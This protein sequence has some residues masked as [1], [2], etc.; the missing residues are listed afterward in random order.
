MF[1]TILYLRISP[2]LVRQQ[3]TDPGSSE[4]T[5]QDNHHRKNP[6]P[7]T[8]H[9]QSTKNQRYRKNPKRIH[10]KKTLSIEKQRITSDFFS[11]PMQ[12]RRE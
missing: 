5:K 3:T 11:E 8:Y 9:F 1:E 6:Y 4:N 12:A 10:R 7:Y 2:I